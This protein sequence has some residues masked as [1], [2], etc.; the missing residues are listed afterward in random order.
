VWFDSFAAAL[1]M[2][3]HG[4]Y[5]WLVVAVSVLVIALLL[6]APALANRGILAQQRGAL[7]R[8]EREVATERASGS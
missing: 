6:I 5:V 1:A 2:D 8:R 7:R 4:V 3:G